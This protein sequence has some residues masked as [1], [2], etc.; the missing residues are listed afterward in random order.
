MHFWWSTFYV[1]N[2]K[3]VVNFLEIVTT[4]RSL[5]SKLTKSAQDSSD[6]TPEAQDSSYNYK[7]H[8]YLHKVFRDDEETPPNQPL[9]YR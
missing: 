6:G 5:K 2:I 7:K 3:D 8:N 1:G 4:S 9:Q